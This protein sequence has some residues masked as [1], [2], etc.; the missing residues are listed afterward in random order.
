MR[1]RNRSCFAANES[2]WRYE[3]CVRKDENLPSTLPDSSDIEAAA[4]VFC[5][6]EASSESIRY[7]GLNS[8]FKRD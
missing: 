1:A 3:A 5:P 7:I 4:T 8:R 6:S 2:K